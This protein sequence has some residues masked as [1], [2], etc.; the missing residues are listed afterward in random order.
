MLHRQSVRAADVETVAAG[1]VARFQPDH[2]LQVGPVASADERHGTAG[3]ER[4][5][6]VAHVIRQAGQFRAADDGCQRAV[7]IQKDGRPT[8]GGA[9]GDGVEPIQ[10]RRE[11]HDVAHARDLGRWAHADFGQVGHHRVGAVGDQRGVIPPPGHA[12]HQAEPA[13]MAGLDARV[14]VLHHDRTAGRDGQPARGFQIGVGR[15]LAGQGVG[16]AFH[17]VHAHVEQAVDTGP[18][19]HDLAVFAGR[20]DRDLQPAVS[21]CPH[22]F[23]GRV[24]DLHAGLAQAVQKSRVLAVAQ[25]ADGFPRFIVVRVALGQRDAARRQKAAHPVVT[26]L[27]VH[28]FQIVGLGVERRTGRARLARPAVQKLVEQLLPGDGVQLFR[29][30]NHTVQVEQHRVEVGRGNDG[31]GGFWHETGHDEP[32]GVSPAGVRSGGRGRRSPRAQD[33]G[34]VVASRSSLARSW[35]TKSSYELFPMM[36]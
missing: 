20:D 6:G 15:R 33:A 4:G 22:E 28:V 5:H 8:A 12:Q 14:G 2:A 34:R 18:F 32:R 1:V 10:R 31:P 35:R 30:G 13:A 19:Q 23:D 11:I 26:L 36:R 24:E 17:P 3:G 21:Q 16:R 9:A 7:I 25:P 29:L 27:A